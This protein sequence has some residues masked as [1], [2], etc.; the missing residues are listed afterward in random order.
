M[1]DVALRALLE[2]CAGG[3]LSI[4]E[5]IRELRYLPYADLGFARVDHHRELRLGLPE[6][7]YGPGKTPEHVAAIVA[8]LLD[9]NT[10]PILVTRASAEQ[11]QA[12]L[13]VTPEAEFLSPAALIV[14]RRAVAAAGGPTL[15][16]VS[17]GTADLPVAE[18]AACTADALGV[19]VERLYDVGVAGLHRLLAGRA[20]LDRAAA[21]IVVAGMD[22]ALASVVGGLLAAPVIAVPTSVGYGAG[23]GGIAPLLTMLNACAPGVVAVNIDNGFGAAVF[24]TLMLR[25][26]AVERAAASGLNGFPG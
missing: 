18:E 21:V 8:A 4:D 23:A 19:L 20:M 2:Q 7:V 26:G 13:A 9:A 11:Y 15:A 1:D 25:R 14:A 17:A 22:G 24:A 5:V 10:G 6:A 16:V 12:V 3:A